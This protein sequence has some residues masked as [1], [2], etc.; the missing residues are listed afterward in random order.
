M[1]PDDR[2]FSMRMRVWLPLGALGSLAALALP[3][4][5]GTIGDSEPDA[6]AAPT[7]DITSSAPGTAS[8]AIT[9]RFGFSAD[10]AAFVG[11]TL[12]FSLRGG[13]VRSGTFVR[14]SAR[15][16]TVV[17]EPNAN[18]QGVIEL[19]VPAG[20]FFEASGRNANTVAYNFSQAYDTRL[21]ATE[22][23]ATL[24][25]NVSGTARG[26][27]VLTITFNLDVGD[28]FALA[29]LLVGDAAPSG[30]TK[31]SGTEYRVTLTPPAAAT[32]ILIVTLPAGAVTAPSSGQS[33]GRD[34]S[35]A[36]FYA[37]P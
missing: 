18:A 29:D 35:L 19:S 34:Y 9:L 5:G 23:G 36:V 12:P 26:A 28:S 15:E 27:F 33:N 3:G 37:T 4:C 21:P 1:T 11:G 22:P 10:T 16:S 2:L 14:V 20:A 25:P 13:R 17:I 8:G 30:F 24:T 6:G 7:L 31:A 32:G